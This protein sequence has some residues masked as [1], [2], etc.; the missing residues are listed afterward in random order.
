MSLDRVERAEIAVI[1]CL[2]FGSV[3]ALL[4][5]YGRWG[6]FATRSVFLSDFE[7]WHWLRLAVMLTL[8][9]SLAAR[10]AL[11]QT[12]KVGVLENPLSYAVVVVPLVVLMMAPSFDS[13]LAADGGDIL[14]LLALMALVHGWGFWFLRA[15]FRR[16]LAETQ[17]Q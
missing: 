15:L 14:A 17:T 2:G 1:C 6:D 7:E 5:A 8:I 4:I 9:T 10:A 3:A 11:V 16:R 12:R 13:F